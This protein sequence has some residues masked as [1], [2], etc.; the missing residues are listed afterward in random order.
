[1]VVK[2]LIVGG[3]LGGLFAANLLHRAGWDVLVC[4]RSGEAL[5]GRGAGLVSHAALFEA[6]TAAGVSVD[7]REPHAESSLGVFVPDRRVFSS[8]GSIVT[9]YAYPQVLA[10]WPRLY[11]VLRGALPRQCYRHGA[12]C[13][14]VETSDTAACAHFADGRVE[15]AD[16]LVAADGLRSTI[17]AQL[18][19]AASPLYAGYIAWRGLVDESRLSATT[20]AALGC[21]F[22]FCVPEGEQILGYPVRVG[23]GRAYNFVW[24]RPVDET[25]LRSMLTDAQGQLHA[26]GIA[27][28]LIRAEWVAQMRNDAKQRLSPAFAEIIARTEQPFFQPI[29]DLV[30]E[31]LVFGRTAL[32][33]DAAFVARPHVGMGVT[34]AA[35]DAVTLVNALRTTPDN[36]TVALAAYE[37]DRV[38]AGRAVVERGRQLGAYMQAQT[39]MPQSHAYVEHLRSPQQVITQTAVPLN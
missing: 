11:E 21:T 23:S 19:P 1:L 4:E 30:S 31:T 7:P 13:V 10:S 29:S 37:A 34:K 39:G 38:V 17:R 22:G 27:P 18:A 14:R 28:T 15:S 8:D 25:T 20:W 32:M 16:L 3:S 35:C 36:I 5:S 33:G 26:D 2:V 24:Y 12:H 6:L 9:Q